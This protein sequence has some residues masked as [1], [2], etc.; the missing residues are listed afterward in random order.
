MT[1]RPAGFLHCFL[2]ASFALPRRVTAGCIGVSLLEQSSKAPCILGR[3]FGCHAADG[4]RQP[5]FWVRGC[6]GK[7]K[8]AGS[9]SP[10]PCG[11]PP[12]EE[13]YRCWC[14]LDCVVQPSPARQADE[15]YCS[16][17]PTLTR[18][19]NPAPRAVSIGEPNLRRALRR[20]DEGDCIHDSFGLFRIRRGHPSRRQRARP[21]ET[22]AA[23]SSRLQAC[24]RR[25]QQCER[26]R[27]VSVVT[28]PDMPVACAWYSRCPLDNLR[29]SLG[30]EGFRTHQISTAPLSPP[31]PP[32]PPPP[33]LTSAL[34]V[35]IA[36]ISYDARPS[37]RSS[38]G[39]HCGLVGWCSSARRLRSALK[40]LVG[41]VDLLL[42]TPPTTPAANFTYDAHLADCADVIT[43]RADAALVLAAKACFHR[44]VRESRRGGCGSGWV[45]YLKWALLAQ[46][47]Y[48]VV[49]YADLDVDLFPE[50]L[51]HREI[52]RH[53]A[54]LLPALIASGYHIVGLPDNSAPLNGG[55][56]IFVPI[57]Q[58]PGA[59][60]LYDAGLATLQRCEVDPLA[61]WDRL[62]A[63]LSASLA[64]FHSAPSFEPLDKR[65][66]G[67]T[68]EGRA[69]GRESVL[70]KPL[71]RR[72]N[73]EW[74]FV[75]AGIDQGFLFHMLFHKF[76]VG[77][78]ASSH[79]P[80]TSIHWWGP[81]KPW[82]HSWAPHQR[83]ADLSIPSRRRLQASYEYLLRISDL[84]DLPPTQCT[85]YLLRLREEI[86][87]AADFAPPRPYSAVPA[88]RL[89]ERY[90]SRG[91]ALRPCEPPQEEEK[92][93]MSSVSTVCSGRDNGHCSRRNVF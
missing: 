45:N 62:G 9:H 39:F 2:F 20:A 60:S 17:F 21:N 27:F 92:L 46:P 93:R 82:R 58:P 84:D 56:L 67:P 23:L 65:P 68:I 85:R 54:E 87:A 35:G 22:T 15:G 50:W 63:N 43:V 24:A 8:C 53:W 55:T 19:N 59:N 69:T 5:T 52:S 88:Q 26:C 77:A 7:F 49:L 75:A 51:W 14:N 90:E 34:R 71:R 11:Y 47:A 18:L 74:T 76:H 10:V 79:T 44:C 89:Q 13:S 64:A 40:S 48:D 80:H 57:R 25:C 29:P 30:G 33:S 42:L 32:P 91:A 72:W 1:H 83:M 86:E 16:F 41:D 28:A 4:S 36:T 70:L 37:H 78:Y 61:G 6:R 3:S 38:A 12:G 66:V 31:P 81:N 73:G